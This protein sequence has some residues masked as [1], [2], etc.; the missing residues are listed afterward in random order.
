MSEYWKSTPKYWCKHCKT[1]V[2]DTKLSRTQHDA[3]AKHQGAL[4]RFLRD[5]HR[6][7]ERETVSKHAARKEVERLN[8][9]TSGKPLTA[10][11]RAGTTTTTKW[12][13]SSTQPVSEAEQKAQLKQLESLGVA[14]PEEFRKEV[15]L[16]GEWMATA[17]EGAQKRGTLSSKGKQ[18]EEDSKDA[19]KKEI[20]RKRN[21]DEEARRWEEMD[22]DERAIKKFKVETKTY[23][24]DAEDEE[25]D[26]L[27]GFRK[28]KVP[29]VVKKEEVQW[30]ASAV[31]KEEVQWGA[32]VKE[33]VTEDGK[34]VKREEEDVG[35]FS[36]DG[37]AAVVKP[38]EGVEKK[39]GDGIAFKKRKVGCL[40]KK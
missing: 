32:R 3:T 34:V 4:N 25:L 27:L 5:L 13:S 8:A 12:A 16:P 20:L 15:A 9:L 18:A 30:G 19:I 35:L 37:G 21:A 39:L 36:G 14:L 17:S 1:F 29:A 24:G 22:E 2:V 23:P 38:E 33:E 28:G 6:A 31:V 10:A 40:R 7:N 26:T 11:G